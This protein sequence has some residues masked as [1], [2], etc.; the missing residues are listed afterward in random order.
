MPTAITTN[1]SGRTNPE[2]EEYQY[3]D[4]IT[5]IITTGQ[6]RPD[7]TGTGVIS[8]F[9]PPSLR[10]SLSNQT[11]PLLT[12]K[13]VFLRGVWEELLW[14]V[15]G[16]TDGKLLSE[17]GIN[18]WDGNGSREYLDKVGLSHRREGDLGPVYGFQWRFFGAEYGT[19]DDDYNGKGVDQLKNVIEKIKNNPTDRR[20]ILSAWNPKDL[21]LMA[22]PPC[23]MF[24]Q[25]YVTLPPLLPSNPSDPSNP[26]NPSD[27]DS[28]QDSSIDPSGP[29]DPN[30][31]PKLSCLMYQRSCDL[32]L[33]VP[34]NIASYALLT[35]MIA[36]VTDCEAHELILQMGDAHVYKDHIEPLKI[37][38]ER[39]PR[40]FPKL[41]WKRS[42]EEISDIDGF[43]SDDLEVLG[44]K[45]LG[46]IEM[47]MSA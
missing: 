36:L 37:Q 9:A 47:K 13:R 46:K 32:G 27:I 41:N 2:H 16:S 4:L 35:H 1:G 31:K 26:S 5:R 28:P 10:F 42:K 12:T 33:G 39:Q 43:K 20:I 23:H 45:P 6:S 29:R 25:F 24:C 14:F 11:L 34:F 44:Y 7:R 30:I 21:P 15:K 38:L 40:E 8:L 19:C 17:K 22:L 18:I 3:L